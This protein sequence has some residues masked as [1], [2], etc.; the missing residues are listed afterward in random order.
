MTWSQGA[1]NG[2]SPVIDYRISYKSAGTY[3]T[4]ATGVTTTF[5]TATALTPD[6]VY[7]FKIEA[8]NLVD[9][10]AYSSEV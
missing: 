8:R 6:T 3:T 7:T 10:S 2:G 4:L 9:Y 5:Y 1:Y